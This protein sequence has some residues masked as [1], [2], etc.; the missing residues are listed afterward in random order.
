MQKPYFEV[1]DFPPVTLKSQNPIPRI[2]NTGY[3]IYNRILNHFIIASTGDLNL[4][5]QPLVL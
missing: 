5:P 1:K 3:N 2:P 4:G